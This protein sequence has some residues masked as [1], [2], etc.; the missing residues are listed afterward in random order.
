MTT[1]CG[2]RSSERHNGVRL[3]VRYSRSRTQ[4]P[5]A[6]HDG[7]QIVRS[8]S[9]CRDKGR[10]G[11]TISVSASAL[12]PLSD[13]AIYK[14]PLC[15]RF[16]LPAATTERPGVFHQANGPTA[17]NALSGPLNSDPIL[18]AHRIAAWNCHTRELVRPILCRNGFFVSG[19]L[20]LQDRLLRRCSVP[21]FQEN[22]MP[23][24][25]AVDAVPVAMVPCRAACFQQSVRLIVV[26]DASDR[27]L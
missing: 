6:R 15:C 5:G 12:G 19:G 2:D 25:L 27:F 16:V 1:G 3:G 4:S 11:S 7:H 23:G 8:A 22:S 26:V 10:P 20:C 13:D 18:M 24:L 17:V 9:V 14:W 21:E